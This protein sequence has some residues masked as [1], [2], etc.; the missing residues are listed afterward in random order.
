MGDI[1]AFLWG[2]LFEVL[3][4]LVGRLAV[5]ALSLGFWR[6]ERL[7]EDEG[8]IYGAAGALSF[9]RD[10]QRVITR[11]GLFWIGM[12]SVALLVVLFLWIT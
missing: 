6:S 5:G 12:V 3:F 2:Y 7:L 11:E 10:G 4:V 9:V 1:L 8:R